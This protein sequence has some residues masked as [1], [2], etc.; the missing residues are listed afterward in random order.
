[1]AAMKTQDCIGMM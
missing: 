1:M